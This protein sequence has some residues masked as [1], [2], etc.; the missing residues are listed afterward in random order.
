[1]IYQALVKATKRLPLLLLA[2]S[3]LTGPSAFARLSCG[4]VFL[5]SVNSAPVSP[6]QSHHLEQ[7]YSGKGRFGQEFIT[8]Q[9]KAVEKKR[10]LRK[11]VSQSAE[12]HD[13]QI[14]PDK[15]G[16]IRWGAQFLPTALKEMLGINALNRQGQ[17]VDALSPEVFYVQVPT[18]ATGRRVLTH[19]ESK[20]K[21]KNPHY[22]LINFYETGGDILSGLQYLQNFASRAELPI[23]KEGHLFEHDLNYHYYSSLVTPSFF[24]KALQNRAQV[25]LEFHRFVKEKSL[26]SREY[27]ELFKA[28]SENHLPELVERIDLST[29]NLFGSTVRMKSENLHKVM[30]EVQESLDHAFLDETNPYDFLGKFLKR[31]PVNGLA[32]LAHREFAPTVSDR[33]FET[34][35]TK[36]QLNNPGELYNEAQSQLKE[37]N[38]IAAELP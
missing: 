2:I 22:K 26:H 18:P 29:G 20:M 6:F 21:Q 24:T 7:V 17:S 13:F 33:Y 15:P 10:F 16:D 37:F 36:E 19:L 9:R 1:M 38:R 28:L 12:W 30:N 32:E 27:A 25:F 3:V 5:D 31:Y 35:I 34:D 8:L 14:N 23:S 11:T 4:P